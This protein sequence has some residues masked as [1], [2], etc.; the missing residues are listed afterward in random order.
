LSESSKERHGKARS[1]KSISTDLKS[2]EVVELRKNKGKQIEVQSTSKPESPV[3]NNSKTEE[4]EVVEM[5]DK[6]RHG[7][8]NADEEVFKPHVTLEPKRNLELEVAMGVIE[9]SHSTYKVID[10]TVRAEALT[11]S[12]NQNTQQVPSFA[13]VE[14]F[15]KINAKCSDKLQKISEVKPVRK[16][17]NFNNFEKR[18]KFQL[19]NN[20]NYDRN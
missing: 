8:L 7:V 11:S 1:N 14:A 4:E 15:E 17:G 19:N 10:R 9:N 12:A 16:C 6:F 20:W 18:K 2:K 3:T 5:V 13:T